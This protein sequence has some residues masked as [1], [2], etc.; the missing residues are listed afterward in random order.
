MISSIL[1]KIMSHRHLRR[2]FYF[3]KP[4]IPRSLQIL[5]RRRIASRKRV[6]FRTSWPIDPLAGS[7]PEHW[8][9]WPENKKFALIISHDVDTKRGYDRC[10]QLL[11]L[12]K[13]L[14]FR[15]SFN[16]VPMRYDVAPG[17]RE[18][19]AQEGFSIGV[20][21]FDHNG[22][23][24]LSRTVFEKHAP[25]INQYLRTWN[26]RGFHSP[27]MQRRED[28]ISELAIDYA[29]S[30][31]DTDPF[32]PQPEGVASIFPIGIKDKN[33]GLR[34][35]ELPYT[36]PQDHGLFI[37]LREK[38][39]QVWRDK[40]D[41]IVSKGG[42]ALINTHPD[43]MNF[44]GS[45]CSLEEYP[46]RYY[47]DF[48]EYI[49]SRYAGEYWHVLHQD[50]ARFWRKRLMGIEAENEGLS[51]EFQSPLGQAH[52]PNA[53]KGLPGL[54][55]S[56]TATPRG[57]ERRIS[58]RGKTKRLGLVCSAGGHFEQLIN[59]M[60]FIKDFDHFWITGLNA[61]TSSSLKNE[62]VYY[63]DE[64]HFKKPWTYLFQ[65]P[66]FVLIL[67]K[68]RP[69][70]LLS[71]GSGRIALIPFLLSFLGGTKFVYIDTFSHVKSYTK[72]GSFINRFGH[73]VLYQ[74]ES[75]RKEKTYYIGPILR[76]DDEQK[77]NIPQ[78]YIFVTLG[79]RTEPFPRLLKIIE[80]LK[81]DGSISERVIVQAGHTPYT[82]DQME[83]FS[84]CTP[85]EIDDYILHANFVITQESAG[86][87]SKCL[88]AHTRFLV[89]PRD[90]RFGELPAE[91]DM[92]EDLHENLAEL[93]YTYVSHNIE[94][95]KTA[96]HEIHK[97]KIGFKFDNSYAL[98]KLR[99]IFEAD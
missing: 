78:G 76:G 1:Q 3:I 99:K 11:N 95:T 59:L 94:E 77:K 53:Q 87:G 40:L 80:A 39:G 25:L 86:I 84:F 54:G 88:K 71:T 46:V 66:K 83:V 22:K 8:S 42:M 45:K 82:S 50:I 12:D 28:W 63:V 48:L 41:W 13:N 61:Q 69:T 9:G 5:V 55:L 96:I 30:T 29:C 36:L 32:E 81:R 26:S 57:A 7:P 58:E 74:W 44:S 34:Y 6:H 79:T 60:D 52:G 70:H 18:I 92:R 65:L 85:S 27:S 97:L 19:I 75:P 33:N 89:I 62:K 4:G 16:F 38:D 47:S 72:L 17:L 67:I 31:F 73:P 15:S 2:T 90:Y 56:K 91:S 21:G 68:E 98:A 35:I 10:L 93:G 24:F 64:A 37:I 20:H 43:Y 49:K 23:L 14:G 51:S